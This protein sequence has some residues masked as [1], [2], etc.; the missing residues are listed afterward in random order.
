MKIPG[1]RVSGLKKHELEL[2][3]R[4]ARQNHE[5]ANKHN[6]RV[7]YLE[8]LKRQ[9]QVDTLRMEHDNLYAARVKHN[10]L[11]AAAERRLADLKALIPQS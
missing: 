7:R 2:L 11:S 5:K 1:A 9:R 6:D 10:G 8:N 4:I 3:M